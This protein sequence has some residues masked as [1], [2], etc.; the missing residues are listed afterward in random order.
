MKKADGAK[1]TAKC[2]RK[3][4]VFDGPNPEDSSALSRVLN[5]SVLEH[6]RDRGYDISTLKFEITRKPVSK[7]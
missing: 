6:F 1:L 2:V 7:K 3:K 5:D 4:L